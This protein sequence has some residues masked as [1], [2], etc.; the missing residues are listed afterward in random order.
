[1]R[2]RI[3]VVITA[4]P[5]Y[6]RVKTVLREIKDHPELELQLLV[7][8]SALLDRFGCVIDIIR[9]DGFEPNDEIY[10]V[11]D[12]EN[13]VTSAKSTGLGI[14]E[15]AKVFDKLKPHAVLSIADRYE[16]IAT[17]ITAAYMN[18]PV[19]HIQGGEITGSIDEKVRHAV[20]KLADVHMVANNNAAE[21]VKRLGERPETVFIT[22]CP[23]I[24]LASVVKDRDLRL[25]KKDL[26][27]GVGADISPDEDYIIVMHHPVT[28][29]WRE[30]G[31]HVTETLMA[32]RA[33]E[34]PTF[35]FWPNVDAGSDGGSKAI[36]IYREQYGSGKIHF[37][38]NLPPENFLILL[39]HSKCLVGNSSAG[40]REGAFLG[41][42]TV[43]IGTRQ[44]GRERAPNVI[45]VGY[46][47]DQIGLAVK[48]QLDHGMYP[49]NTMYGDGMAG[50]RIAEL[51]A[52][53]ELTVQ[54]RITY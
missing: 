12:G 43:N 11:V 28:Y 34:I 39:N 50:P 5:S 26:A 33:L 44:M 24:D 30:A 53:V 13:L 52:S 42:P 41:V 32:I 7:A 54:K 3:C 21:R 37:I 36:R 8:G 10:M 49:S 15:L 22:G 18:I 45:D 19:V 35:W 4:R 38:R 51:L 9:G 27:L 6:A 48:K 31:S 46:Q 16:T 14:L 29:E 20:T 40:I 17:A 1:M 47:R 23:S 2:R 25:S